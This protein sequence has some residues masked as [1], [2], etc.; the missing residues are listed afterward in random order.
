[1]DVFPNKSLLLELRDDRATL[2]DELR[3]NTKLT[4]KLVS[5]Y[6][7]KEFIG[8]VDDCGF[9]IISSEIG[10]GALCVFE[11]DFQDS[12][13]TVEI[14]IN[15]AFKIL[16][17]ILILMPIIGFVIA[18]ATQGIEKSIG[19]IVPVI[20][21]IL[22]IRFVFLEL[23]FRFISKTGLKKLTRIIGLKEVKD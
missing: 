4:N 10:R 17:S 22:F 13:G 7:D 21:L 1:M 8:Q 3:R 11:G 18:I 14:R 9:K 19:F 5:E 15:S 20:M 2:L 16:F 6:T 23:S 12:F